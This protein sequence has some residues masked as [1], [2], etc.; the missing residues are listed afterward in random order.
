MTKLYFVQAAEKPILHT[1][2]IIKP[3][4]EITQKS[5]ALIEK[6]RERGCYDFRQLSKSPF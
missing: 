6:N 4:K 1:V 3:Y 5:H 2:R